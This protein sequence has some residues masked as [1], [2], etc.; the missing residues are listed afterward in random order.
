VLT[1][2]FAAVGYAQ[3]GRRVHR[4]RLD[5]PRHARPCPLSALQGDRRARRL[6]LRGT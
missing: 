4:G 2:S 5:R 1:S 6:G 3:G